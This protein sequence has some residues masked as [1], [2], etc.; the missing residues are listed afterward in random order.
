MSRIFKNIAKHLAMEGGVEVVRG[1]VIERMRLV[2]AA[3]L[4]KAIKDHTHTLS[5]A[6]N[7]DKSF[8][9]KW[10]KVIEKYTVDGKQLRREMMTP[11]NVLAWLCSD[12]PDLGSLIINMGAEGKEWLKTDVDEL[13]KFLFGPQQAP[14]AVKLAKAKII[15]PPPPALTHE[16][17]DTETRKD[18]E[19]C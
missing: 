3:D 12:R 19:P 13:F 6:E 5:V 14:P 18:T 4:Y 9:Q 17:L 10:A 7:R 8:G 16:Q 15:A 1:Y 2:T 11:E